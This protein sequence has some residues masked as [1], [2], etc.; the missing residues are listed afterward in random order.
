MTSLPD[1]TFARYLLQTG[2]VTDAQIARARQRQGDAAQ[3]GSPAA[4]A[5]VMVSEGIITQAQRENVQQRLSAQANTVQQLGKFKLIK[6]LGEGGMGAVYLAEDTFAFRNVALKLLHRKFSGNR[7][8]LA[9]FRRE[10]QAMARLNHANIVAAF[11]VAEE[12][13]YHYYVM[14][15]CEGE[16]LDKRVKR[17]RCLPVNEAIDIAIQVARGLEYAHGRNTI[18]RDIKPGNIFIGSDGT[19]KILDLGL[20]KNLAEVDTSFNTQAGITVG[21]PHYISPEQARGDADIDGRTDIYS[22]GATLYHLT[23]GRTPFE[24]PTSVVIMSKHLSEQIDNPADINPEISDGLVHVITK[25]MAKNPD[26]RHLNCTEVLEDLERVKTGLAPSS[27]VLDPV[28]SSVKPRVRRST[29][30]HKPLRVDG[31]G[32][33]EALIVQQGARE[34]RGNGDAPPANTADHERKRRLAFVMGISGAVLVLIAIW[35]GMGGT[36]AK[37]N[38]VVAPP[39]PPQPQPEQE[40]LP[41]APPIQLPPEDPATQAAYSDTIS[42]LRNYVKNR[43]F[44]RARE[45]LSALEREVSERD[46]YDASWCKRLDEY[47]LSV[48]EGER[49]ARVEFRSILLNDAPP[50]PPG[51][52]ILFSSNMS[53]QTDNRF[54]WSKRMLKS[55]RGKAAFLDGQDASRLLSFEMA[56]GANLPP[57]ARIALDYC[58]LAECKATLRIYE[59]SKRPLVEESKVLP[60]SNKFNRLEFNTDRKSMGKINKIEIEFS[61]RPENLAV[62]RI[63][64]RTR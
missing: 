27:A 17:E 20:S 55:Y 39:A 18:H 10:A 1:E 64:V 24:G 37:P 11:D 57:T 29:G 6:K 53:E 47:E 44:A 23:T 52:I 38:I 48:S 21:T 46:P 41:P 13:G 59:D 4:L 2:M 22:L 36:S 8:F 3:G 35:I 58:S 60:T 34:A 56:N 31:P 50:S 16:P 61:A 32:A 40:P 43:D 12:N 28:R 45:R 62:Y 25:M 49:Q 9:R 26:D 19:A 30:Q 42:L 5:D 33:R 54:K 63:Y 15:Y 14:E 51:S 7:D